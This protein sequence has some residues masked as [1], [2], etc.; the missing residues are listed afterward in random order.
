M[1]TKFFL[2]ILKFLGRNLSMDTWVSM[3]R[4]IS[5]LLYW[6][7]GYRRKVVRENLDT[8]LGQTLSTKEIDL[9]EK[10]F[11]VNL[12]ELLA[13]TIKTMFLTREE[14]KDL[15]EFINPP[16]WETITK[17]GR[18]VF[19]LSGHY[20]NWEV[21]AMGA[22][23]YLP[24]QAYGVYKPLSNPI[25]EDFVKNGRGNTGGILVP[26]NEFASTLKE[27]TGN[28]GGFFG[29]AADQSPPGYQ[30][31]YWMNFLNKETAV[32]KGWANLA[33]KYNCGCYYFKAVKENK[34]FKITFEKVTDAAANEN[35]ENLIISYMRLLERDIYK[36]PELWVWSHNRWKIKRKKDS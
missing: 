34:K 27:R 13:E 20:G 29:V 18:C 17:E 21:A 15:V 31:P 32:I 30:E 10:K 11:Y 33:V 6:P 24:A 8:T 2:A 35:E 28:G 7:I 25:M 3:G 23:L 36:K 1:I 14:I 16:E 26:T 19:L 9:I 22:D 5:R 12:G 4:F